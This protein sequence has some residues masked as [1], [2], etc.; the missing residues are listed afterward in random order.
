MLLELKVSNFAIIDN[1]HIEFGKG[2]NI[3][4]G[5]T[6]AGKSILM[7]S[8]GLLMGA[9]ASSD[10]IRNENETATIEGFF[11][12]SRRPDLIE[13]LAEMGI[14][15]DGQLIVR[16]L[17]SAQGKS[18]VYINGSLNP[19]TTLQDLVA[20]MIEVTGQAAPLIEMTAQSENRNLLSKA[21]HLMLLD[22]FC[23]TINLRKEFSEKYHRFNEIGALIEE[24]QANEKIR[25]QKLDFLT[26]QRDEIKSLQV[27]PGEEEE[28]ENEYLRLRHSS[29]LHKWAEQAEE[30]LYNQDDSP[31]VKIHRVIQ[32]AQELSQYDKS[33]IEKIEPLQQAKALIDDAVRELRAYS[34]GLESEPE[35]LE[36][37]EKRRSD[38]KTLMKK[39]GGSVEEILKSFAAIEA[40]IETLTD[41]EARIEEL[42]KERMSLS[43]DLQKI[44]NDL[45]KRRTSG[46]ILLANEVNDEL[47]DLNMKGVVFDVE[48]QLL[49][50][51]TSTGISDVEFV[52]KS[53]AKDKSRSLGKS[54][55]GGELSRILLSLKNVVGQSD[56]PR[57]YLFDE[58]D[59]GVSGIT[60]EKVGKKLKSIAKDQQVICVTHLPQVAS[61][62]D[63][64]FLIEKN[65]TGKKVSTEIRALKKDERV[66][67][68]ARLISGEKI[69]KTSIAHA[70]QLLEGTL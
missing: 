69:T 49:S 10:M 65:T 38:L 28:I 22:K 70:K 12:I 64:H 46:A 1:V 16:R 9:K 8:L 14:D 66:T 19:L 44:G 21:Y 33:I 15:H 31:L 6:G 26:F 56:F 63:V 52:I 50:E 48:I 24:I 3:L 7:K 61:A 37:L 2:L 55:S 5:E 4:S 60:A 59:T 57:T 39:Y 42:N 41:S 68:V 27:R 54:A 58:V 51:F 13:K 23:S 32:R 18:R 43:K 25:A 40:E 62:G 29:Q 11:D 45:H 20:P 36:Q 30:S 67:E 47:N 17:V 34:D 53:T 35:R